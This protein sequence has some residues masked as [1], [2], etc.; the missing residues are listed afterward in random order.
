MEEI[1]LEPRPAPTEEDKARA[2]EIME[3]ERTGAPVLMGER[4]FA[5]RVRRLM[6][7]PA[8][9]RATW[10]QALRVGEL[11]I[12]GVPGEFFCELGL[13]IKRRSPFAQT[14]VIEL[15]NDSVG[16]IP[17]R[18]AFEEGAYEPESSPYA[19]GFGEEIVETAVRL[20]E[21]LAATP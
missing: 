2:E 15:A 14:M 13:E 5:R 6:D 10:V 18:R 3:R 9:P 16:Y 1:V 19:A 4:S 11:G 20:L 8:E 21:G 7:R 17:T 12:A